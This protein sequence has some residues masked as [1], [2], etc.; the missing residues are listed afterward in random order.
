MS[1]YSPDGW[2]VLEINDENETYYKIFGSWMG[3]FTDG[4]SWRLSSGSELSLLE[5]REKL[6]SWPQSSGSIYTL[7]KSGQGQ[8]TFYNRGVLESILQKFSESDFLAEMV[9]IEH[10]KV[11]RTN[12]VT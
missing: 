11:E 3:G 6:Y 4:D 9:S 10:G 12:K 7:T 2:V 8:L 5:V 1:E